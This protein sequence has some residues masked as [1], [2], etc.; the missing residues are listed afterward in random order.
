MSV[1]ILKEPLPTQRPGFCGRNPT[2]GGLSVQSSIIN[3]YSTEPRRM[4]LIARRESLLFW[5]VITA[6]RGLPVTQSIII[7]RYPRSRIHGDGDGDD[8]A[9][10]AETWI[11]W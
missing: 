1:E 9:T 2:Q 4:R 11:S 3:R 8:A 5:L 7:D 6:E 10:D